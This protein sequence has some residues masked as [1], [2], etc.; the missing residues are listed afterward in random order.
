MRAAVLRQVDAP[1]EVE[2]VEMTDPIDHEVVVKVVAAGLC[3]S[4]VHFMTG[5]YPTR[6]PTIVGHESAGVVE[7]VGPR[8]THV[9]PGD[10]VVTCLSMFCGTCTECLSG[11]PNRCSNRAA[12]RRPKEAPPRLTAG[13]EPLSQLYDLGSFAERILVSE[14]AV[15]K[16]RGDMPLD[17]ACLLGCGVTTGLGAVF[18]TAGVRPG[19]SMAVIGCGGIGLG[20][21]QGGRIAGANRVIAVDRIPDKLDFARRLGAT[22][23]V[24]AGSA[25]V[26][27]AVRELTGGGVDHAFEAIG[28]ATTARQAFEM[29]RRG[30]VATV[31]GMIP[32]GQDVSVHG[33]DL[34]LEKRLQGSDMGS[35]RFRIDIPRYVEMYLDGRLQLDEMISNRYSLDQINEGFADMRTGRAARNLIVFG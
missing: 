30:G 4:D 19:E 17:R 11:H 15:V 2:D 29:L 16:V 31:I 33:Y 35:N 10:H 28:L 26:V 1:L 21:I 24:D 7:A 25:D 18:N 13:G 20:A 6:L 22:D 3:H 5:A 8:V 27:E 12:N 23:T 32:Y 9:G 34:L 14:N